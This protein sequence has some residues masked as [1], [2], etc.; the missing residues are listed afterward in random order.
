MTAAREPITLPLEIYAIGKCQKNPRQ[1]PKP[2]LLSK[3]HI[4][5]KINP[6][7]P[8]TGQELDYPVTK[9]TFWLEGWATWQGGD[10]DRRLPNV[11][12]IFTEILRCI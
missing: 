9:T 5:G 3:K 8:G 7:L 1:K 2:H 6:F 4:Q 11:F 12:S 10:P